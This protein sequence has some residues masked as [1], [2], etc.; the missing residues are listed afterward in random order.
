MS[1]KQF[2]LDTILDQGVLPLYFYPD[3]AVSIHVLHVLYNAGIRAVEYTNRGEAALHNFKE[4]IEARN[5]EMPGMLLGIG[6]IKTAEQGRAFAA[7]GADF[8]ISP[9]TLPEVA[10]VAEEAGLLYIPGCMTTTEVIVAENFGSTF[11]KL[12]PGNVLG[13]AYVSAIIDLFPGMK[14]MPTGGV[15]VEEGNLKAW[16]KSGVSAVGLGS[17]LISKTIL[18]NRDYDSIARETTKALE[19]VRVIR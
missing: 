13:P 1:K 12:F 17:K 16:F 9:G 5:D 14:F 18:E 19:L 3:T 7:A 11:V 2:A 6:T 4:M 15:E 10:A 8:L